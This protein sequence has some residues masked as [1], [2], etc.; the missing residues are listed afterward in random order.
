MISFREIVKNLNEALSYKVQP[1]RVKEFKNLDKYN[2]T[3]EGD[4]TLYSLDGEEVFSYDNK[5]NRLTVLKHRWQLMNLERG[6]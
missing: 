3:E 5:K 2:K 4:I 6:F 1:D